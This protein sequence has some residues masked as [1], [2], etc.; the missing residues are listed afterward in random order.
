MFS[1]GDVYLKKMASIDCIIAFTIDTY[2]KY[3]S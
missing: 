1:A 2:Y 3:L